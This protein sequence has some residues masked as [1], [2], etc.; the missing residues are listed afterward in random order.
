MG[1]ERKKKK[2][3]I[4][5]SLLLSKREEKEIQGNQFLLE[6]TLCKETKFTSHFL[7]NPQDQEHY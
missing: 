4:P 2:K 5:V 3:K 7:Q 1:S 6:L